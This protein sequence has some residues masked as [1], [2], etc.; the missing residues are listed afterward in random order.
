MDK[1]SFCRRS[2]LYFSDR[3][4]G[5]PLPFWRGLMVRWHLLACPLCHRY[6]RSLVAT[7][8]AVRALR[9]PDPE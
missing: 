9:D 4:D 3:L 1:D 2:R 7:R 5:R 8:D 6:Q